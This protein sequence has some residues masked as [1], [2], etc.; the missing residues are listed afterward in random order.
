LAFSHAVRRRRRP[1]GLP[2]MSPLLFLANS[3]TQ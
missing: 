1:R 2:L 3:D